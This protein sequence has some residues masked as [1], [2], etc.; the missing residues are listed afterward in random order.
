MPF[1]S[2]SRA[3]NGP[4]CAFFPLSLPVWFTSLSSHRVCSVV[5][6]LP[7]SVHDCLY[8]PVR[9]TCHSGPC[10]DDK[11]NHH[12]QSSTRPWK[13][14]PLDYRFTQITY[15]ARMRVWLI[16]E[17]LWIGAHYPPP[18]T[19]SPGMP[20][21]TL[22]HHA[23]FNT[24]TMIHLLSYL[25]E[26]IYSPTSIVINKKT[27]L[28]ITWR[29][30]GL[31]DLGPRFHRSVMSL[32]GAIQLHKSINCCWLNYPKN[33]LSSLSPLHPLF[34]VHA[35]VRPQCMINLE[36]PAGCTNRPQLIRP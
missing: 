21:P 2:H 10:F 35:I 7:C 3:R 15:W 5:F 29:G 13:M 4:A 23:I 26:K 34:G 6:Y 14:I 33:V 16:I 31:S 1:Q 36:I 25:L 11:S 22:V 20:S 9:C 19:G 28:M 24:S 17:N 12:I 8:P 27:I 30:P 32:S 18:C